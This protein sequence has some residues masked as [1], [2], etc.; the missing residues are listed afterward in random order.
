VNGYKH[1]GGYDLGTGKV[2]WQM[3]GGGDIPVPTPVVAHGL[4]YI[5]N[6]HGSAAPLYAVKLDAAGDISLAAEARSNA[7]VAWAHMRNGAYMQTPLVLG[8]FVY[9]SA[10]HGILVCYDA[11]SGE[12]VYRKRLGNGQT[13][14]TASPVAAGDRLYFTSEDGDVYVIQAGREFAELAHN[15]MGEICMATPAISDGVLFVR[16]QGHVVAI[17]KK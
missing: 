4:T 2:L 7:G 6:A 8:D 14:F 13:G 10:D 3:K 5:A 1:I 16:T 9:S 17:G 15:E 11:K 12:R